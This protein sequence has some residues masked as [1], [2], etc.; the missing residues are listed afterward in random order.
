MLLRLWWMSRILWIDKSGGR[1][2]ALVFGGVVAGIV[3]GWSSLLTLAAL[4][5]AWPGNHL[6]QIVVGVWVL[7]AALAVASARRR[8][9][10]ELREPRSTYLTVIAPG[11]LLFFWLAEAIGRR[12]HR[13]RR[14]LSE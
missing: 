4:S 12:K 2:I 14:R 10:R 11:P 9:K 7:A 8:A 3:L 5:I 13:R 1:A 6:V